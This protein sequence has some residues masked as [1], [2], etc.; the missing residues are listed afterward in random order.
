VWTKSKITIKL[1]NILDTKTK[2]AVPP[3]QLYQGCWNVK[4]ITDYFEDNLTLGTPGSYNL[5]MLGLDSKDTLLYREIG[6]P[7]CYLVSATPF[8][9]CVRPAKVRKG[10]YATIT[11]ASFGPI[12]KTSYVRIGPASARIE[13]TDGI[14]DDDGICDP[15]EVCTLDPLNPAVK[16]VTTYSLWS[17]TSIKFKVPGPPGARFVQVVVPG[18]APQPTDSNLYKIQ[19]KL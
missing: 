15:G 14:G 12:R 1:K 8:I 13:I 19:V 11:G 4:V 5:G 2:L 9:N 17:N 7:T 3:E 16:I 6:E 10:T 18:A